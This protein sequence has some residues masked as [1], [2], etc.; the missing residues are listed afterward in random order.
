MRV[1]SLTEGRYWLKTTDNCFVAR[2]NLWSAPDLTY[3]DPCGPSPFL[4]PDD[5]PAKDTT[6]VNKRDS[7]S[8]PSPE[9]VERSAKYLV[10]VT[11]GEE[12]SY[13]RTCAA[14]SC[15][16]ERRYE[17]NQEVYLQCL[18]VLNTTVY[19][20]MT[21]VRQP[22][23]CV[24]SHILT[25]FSRRTSATSIMQTYGRLRKAIFTAFQSAPSLT[26]MTKI[27]AMRTSKDTNVKH[28][29]F[30]S[31]RKIKHIVSLHWLYVIYL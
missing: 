2:K 15:D 3:L 24:H 29:Y 1:L 16:V 23:M 14:D 8:E 6:T 31:N 19:W 22:I 20:S 25:T 12:Y 26:A 28:I 10:N 18:V 27:R 9:L 4:E 13:C 30:T 17:F 21:T 7:E 5:D 11:I